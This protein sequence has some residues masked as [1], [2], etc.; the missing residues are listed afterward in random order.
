MKVGGLKVK[1]I[2]VG[3]ARSFSI[4][5]PKDIVRL[6]CGRYG[7]DPENLEYFELDYDGEKILLKPHVDERSK[8]LFF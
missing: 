6:I 1:V 2:R 4:V 7:I 3:N 5:I 8:R